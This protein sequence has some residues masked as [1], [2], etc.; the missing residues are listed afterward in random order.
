[1][2]AAAPELICSC[3]LSMY[4]YLKQVRARLCPD[5]FISAA[6]HYRILAFTI[7]LFKTH[8]R[9]LPVTDFLSAPLVNIPVILVIHYKLRGLDIRLNLLHEESHLFHLYFCIALA[10]RHARY[11]APPQYKHGLHY[12]CHPVFTGPVIP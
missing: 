1:M 3:R 7:N 2:D 8:T 12:R 6:S 11:A 5:L 4:D 10:A 9:V